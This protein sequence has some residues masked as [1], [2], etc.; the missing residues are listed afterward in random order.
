MLAVNPERAWC[1][2]DSEVA[3]VADTVD[4]W[5]GKEVMALGEMSV[6]VTTGL[7]LRVE[8]RRYRKL[9]SGIAPST[10]TGSRPNEAAETPPTPR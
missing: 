6:V 3:A 4:I 5:K 8:K 7:V 10:A 9:V 1:L 2:S